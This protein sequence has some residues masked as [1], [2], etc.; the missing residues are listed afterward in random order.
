MKVLNEKTEK[1][2]IAQM[3]R[4]LFDGRI[5]VVQTEG[6]AIKATNFLRSQNLVGLDT[7]TRPTF[8]KG[9]HHQ[10]SLLQVATKEV[11]FLFRL[12]FMGLP[13]CVV[14]MFSDEHLTKVGL[15]L[16]DDL[17]ALRQR[18]EFTPLGFVE[19]QTMAK[20]LSIDDLSLQKLYANLFHERISK[21]QRLSNWEADVLSPQQKL[22]AATD[23]W[24]CINLYNEFVRL[25]A[26]HDYI[27]LP[28]LNTTAAKDHV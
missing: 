22:Y 27:I 25:K 2:S 11:C 19:L 9:Q 24:A 1:E 21:G 14:A 10:V 12:N 4:V 16:H 15:S 3:P 18:R 20:A 17:H 7:E 13:D 8:K 28:P 6:E 5:I 23:A 26:T